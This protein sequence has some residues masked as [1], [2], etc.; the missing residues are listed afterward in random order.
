MDANAATAKPAHGMAE[1]ATAVDRP[2][3]TPDFHI[4][5]PRCII[6]GDMDEFIPVPPGVH[7]PRGPQKPGPD[8][9]KSAER[10]DIEMQQIARVRPFIALNRPWSL[11]RAQAAE[12]M[13]PEHA[14]DGRLG[15]L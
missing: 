9:A 3:R 2:G 5:Q 4:G 13:L 8:G 11:K 1:K 14:P 6:N 7:V 12:T 10:L 15:H